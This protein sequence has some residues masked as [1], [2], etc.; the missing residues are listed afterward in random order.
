MTLLERLDISYNKINS[1]GNLESKCLFSLNADENSFETLDFDPLKVPSLTQVKFGSANCK[2]INFPIVEKSVADKLD[3]Q[4]S[5]TGKEALLIPPHPMLKDP[6]MLHQQINSKEI[7]LQHYDEL[8][9]ESQNQCITWLVG[10]GYVEYETVNFSN[11]TA[12]CSHLEHYGL[13]QLISKFVTIR[14]LNLSNCGLRC[15]PDI[16][17]LVNL[18]TLVLTGNFIEKFGDIVSE[19][20]ICID[21][22]GNP[23]LGYDFDDVNLPGLR[24]LTIGSPKTK[25]ISLD[26]LRIVLNRQLVLQVSEENRNFLVFPTADCLVDHR[27]MSE[28]VQNAKFDM[29]E[30]LAENQLEAFDWALQHSGTFISLKLNDMG[31][32]GKC[33]DCINRL[34]EIPSLVQLKELSLENC[35]LE[36]LPDVSLLNKLEVL[37]VSQNR[38]EEVKS[39]FIPKTL[40]KLHIQEN[41]ILCLD[42]DLDTLNLDKIIFG[43]KSTH[44]ISTP[45]LRKFQETELKLVVPDQFKVH[46]HLPPADALGDQDALIRYLTFPEKQLSKIPDIDNQKVE[47]LKWLL[48]HS[49][50]NFTKLDL[51]SQTWLRDGGLDLR[52]CYLRNIDELILR[53]CRLEKLP[54]LKDLPLLKTLDLRNNNLRNILFG[55][56]LFSLKL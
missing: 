12:F 49:G 31:Q 26:T 17:K 3:L 5:E 33:F 14:E 42:I 52:L 50:T 22:E 41:P 28:F 36:I 20:V 7:T 21:F 35:N 43:S 30:I 55:G 8:N 40:K 51:G 24:H 15:I 9:P 4:V 11:D 1:L 53:N 56:K 10:K 16:K 39:T 19:S 6:K 2:F 32:S 25:Y 18:K 46:L 37:D 44:Y 27:R 23:I 48:L 54:S 34:H 47:A 13:Q 38:I 29:T 45:I